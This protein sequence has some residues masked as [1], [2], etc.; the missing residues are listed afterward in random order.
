MAKKKY[1]LRDLL[2]D[3]FPDQIILFFL[4]ISISLL[5]FTA[6]FLG[7]FP[8]DKQSTVLLW[9]A[10]VFGVASSVLISKAPSFIASFFRRRP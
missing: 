1:G 8:A 3:F 2:I 9:M 6:W 4:G 7:F 10:G 5:A